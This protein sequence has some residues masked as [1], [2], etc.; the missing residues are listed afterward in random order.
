MPFP[1]PAATR[2]T[3]VKLGVRYCMVQHIS[4]QASAQVVKH[5]LMAT[6]HPCEIH[7]SRC[8]SVCVHASHEKTWQSRWHWAERPYMPYT[9]HTTEPSVQICHSCIL[10]GFTVKFADLTDCSVS[11]TRYALHTACLERHPETRRYAPLGCPS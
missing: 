8:E 10:R 1:L 9:T 5:A 3:Y 7:R 4:T 2:S 11:S 6:I